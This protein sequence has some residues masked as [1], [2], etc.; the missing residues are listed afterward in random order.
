MNR[1]K[2][3]NVCAY[4]RHGTIEFRQHQGTTNADKILNWL[5]FCEAMVMTVKAG[6]APARQSNFG[7]LLARLN[8]GPAIRNWFAERAAELT[9]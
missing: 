4:G 1:Y 8:I 2:T 5:A 7:D 3:V 9:A 6:S